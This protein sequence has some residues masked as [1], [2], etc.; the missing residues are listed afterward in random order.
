MFKSDIGDAIK[1]VCADDHDGDA[2]HL[3]RA[4]EIVRREMFEKPYKFTGSFESGCEE[5][6]FHDH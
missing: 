6:M 3:V 2:I 5:N 1:R 4:A